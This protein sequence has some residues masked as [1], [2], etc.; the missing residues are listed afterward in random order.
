[1]LR[2]LGL[3]YALRYRLGRLTLDRALARLGELSGAQVGFGA[4][5]DGRAAI[6]VDK[7]VD[8]DLVRALTRGRVDGTG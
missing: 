1:M 8:L 4:L 5:S 3:G 7:P 6:D 2:R